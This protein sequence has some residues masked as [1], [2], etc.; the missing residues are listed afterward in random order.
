MSAK[1][2]SIAK[3]NGP[4]CR[5]EVAQ[6]APYNAG[7]STEAVRSRYGA[8][9]ITKLGSNENPYG[10]AP[11]VATAL[12]ELV[13][14][15]ALYPE[16]DQKLKAAL[17]AR[18]H[19]PASCILLGNGSE[20]I[21]RMIAEAYINP[22]DRVVTVV[23]SFGLHIITAEAM[24]GKV[25]A[26]PMTPACTFDLPALMK[27]VS[28]PLKV[29]IFAN[30]SNPVGCMM[31]ADD[32]R[33]LFAACPPDCLIVVDEAYY[34]YARFDAAYPDARTILREQERPWLVLR[35]FSKAYG[36]A[37]LRIGYAIGSDPAI[38]DSLGRIRDPFNTNIAAQLA[39]LG[40][41]EGL[42][43]MDHSTGRTV[44]AREKLRG[45]M[46]GMGLT[47]APSYGNFLFFRTERPSGDIAEALLHHG[48]IVK[49]WKEAG[50]THWLR[51]SVGLPDENARF[52]AALRAVLHPAP[53]TDTVGEC[54]K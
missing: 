22:G 40:A 46:E 52:L 5:P 29:L 32:M 51:V 48:V 44:E 34:E 19:E 21:I 33:A 30:P 1:P 25:E 11:A 54:V 14:Q 36:L 42:E 31:K 37:G 45:E 16:A 2:A 26:V 27:A 41:L 7:L 43:H 28:A 18:L 8:T 39:A 20:Q 53:A 23:P 35:T 15:V 3:V 9:T 13:K 10:P 49:P 12:Q 4:A 50:Y 38:I 47:V 6:L 24:G 17:A